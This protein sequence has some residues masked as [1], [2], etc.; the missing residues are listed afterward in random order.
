MTWLMTSLAEVRS[1]R[2]RSMKSLRE[3]T[4]LPFHLDLLTPTIWFPDTL[5]FTTPDF[6]F[7]SSHHLYGVSRPER[8]C[9]DESAPA[10]GFL[11]L[12]CVIY[13]GNER[14]S[15]RCAAGLPPSPLLQTLPEWGNLGGEGA[16]CC[17]RSSDDMI[18]LVL[19]LR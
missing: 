19:Q 11:F 9:N 18:T 7:R 13:S 15:G 3:P 1:C 8:G 14:S 5:Q 10:C 2:K 12:N 17:T 4:P 16:G 6:E